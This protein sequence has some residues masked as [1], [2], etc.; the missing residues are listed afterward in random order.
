[1]CKKTTFLKF[2]L[3]V[4]IDLV[5]EVYYLKQVFHLQFLE[6][7]ST[8]KIDLVE[9]VHYLK[10]AFHLPYVLSVIP[11]KALHYFSLII[12]IVV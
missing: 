12:W 1:M 10:Q 9:V 3:T 5:E 2:C 6:F 8:F 4:K 7:H 11:V